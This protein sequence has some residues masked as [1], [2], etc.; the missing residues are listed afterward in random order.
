MLLAASAGHPSTVYY[1]GSCLSGQSKKPKCDTS[2]RHSTVLVLG[3]P[4]EDGLVDTIASCY[5]EL[6]GSRVVV[7]Y[8]FEL[9]AILSDLRM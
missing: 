7:R 3:D 9:F 1:S 2:S 8:I 4:R 5:S 6:R